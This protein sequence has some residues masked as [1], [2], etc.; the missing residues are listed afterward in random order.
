MSHVTSLIPT[1]YAFPS[2]HS[3]R[4]P[5]QFHG[6]S[7]NSVIKFQDPK[8]CENWGFSA[9][10]IG[11]NSLIFFQFNSSCLRL[12]RCACSYS[13]ANSIAKFDKSQKTC[14][15]K[16]TVH[17]KEFLSLES[18]LDLSSCGRGGGGDTL[19]SLFDDDCKIIE[20]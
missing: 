9:T 16:L 20:S 1:V 4:T 15:K 13:K 14:F 7:E 3:Y 10:K 19:S 18:S 2:Q 11:L 5:I 17:M 12:L 6:F 8:K